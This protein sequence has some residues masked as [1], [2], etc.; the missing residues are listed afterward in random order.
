MNEPRNRLYGTVMGWLVFTTM[1]PPLVL[2]RS[3]TQ[4]SYQWGFASFG[5]TGMAGDLWFIAALFA[6]VLAMMWFGWR[7]ARLPFHLLA[8]LW[9][10]GVAI[11]WLLAVLSMGD[12]ARFRGDT[13]GIDIWLGWLAPVFAAFALI[14]IWWAVGDLRRRAT[15]AAP[16]WTRRNA[17]GFLIAAGFLAAA[18]VLFRMGNLHGPSDAAAVLCVFAFWITLNFWGLR[19]A[20]RRV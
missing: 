7:G 5:G 18:I 1:I 17:T 3:L 14:T 9:T 10:G 11:T 2:T 4:P 12:A 19:P 15:R 6:F 16:G 8:V 13:L 20:R